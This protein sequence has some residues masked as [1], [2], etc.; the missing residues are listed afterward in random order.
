LLLLLCGLIAL[1]W[2]L[3]HAHT[4]DV[5]YAHATSRPHLLLLHVHT[6]ALICEAHPEVLRV[7]V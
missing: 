7:T 6:K 5:W 1:V 4:P 2:T 3:H